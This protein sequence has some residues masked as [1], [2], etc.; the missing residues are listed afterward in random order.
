MAFLQS[1][2]A[3]SQILPKVE[4]LVAK[5]RELQERL[6]TKHSAAVDGY[7]KKSGGREIENRVA[8]QQ[9]KIAALRQGLEDILEFIG[10]I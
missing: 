3:A 2:P 1:S 4:E 6:M 8:A 10:E 5:E 9:Q 7:E